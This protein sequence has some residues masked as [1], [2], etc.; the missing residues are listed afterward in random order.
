[1]TIADQLREAAQSD[2]PYWGCP[3]NAFCAAREWLPDFELLADLD[4]PQIAW[5][6]LLVAE[7]LE[8]E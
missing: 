1:M 8:D 4:L 2:D 5:F 6:F 7:A 3:S